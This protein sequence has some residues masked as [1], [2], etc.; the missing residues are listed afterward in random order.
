MWQPSYCTEQASSNVPSGYDE[1]WLFQPFTMFD[2]PTS[3]NEP[4]DTLSFPMA[5]SV[6]HFM[7]ADGLDTR[8][9]A[10]FPRVTEP[11][12]IP[13]T[14]S[15]INHVTASSSGTGAEDFTMQ[16]KSVPHHVIDPA[17]VFT[18][19]DEQPKTTVIGD[20]ANPHLVP[21][22]GE[23][24]RACKT[25]DRMER[26]SSPLHKRDL[27]DFILSLHKTDLYSHC[28]PQ[29]SC[30]HNGRSSSPR[31]H[32]PLYDDHDRLGARPYQRHPQRRKSDASPAILNSRDG[33]Q[34]S[35]PTLNSLDNHR[36]DIHGEARSSRHHDQPRRP[37]R[38]DDEKG[39]SLATSP[40]PRKRRRTLSPN[41]V[42]NNKDNGCQ[43]VR[44][45]V[46]DYGGE[47]QGR[48]QDT[49][50]QNAVNHPGSPLAERLHVNAPIEE[51]P[52]SSPTQVPL[53]ARTVRISDSD[54]RPTATNP[55]SES[56]ADDVDGC[57]ILGPNTLSP[58]E[59][60]HNPE[61][62]HE[63]DASDDEYDSGQLAR[64]GWLVDPW[65]NEKVKLHFS[66]EEVTAAL[67]NLEDKS[68]PF[69]IFATHWST[70]NQ[71]AMRNNGTFD[72]ECEKEGRRTTRWCRGV[73]V[74]QNRDREPNPCRFIMRPVTKNKK[75]DDQ[76]TK[77]CTN[78][79]CK[80]E[81]PLFRY[82]TCK[83]AQKLRIW[84][85]GATF[86]STG[87]HNHPR[88]ARVLHL[89]P[90]EQQEASEVVK[91]NPTLGPSALRYGRPD[92]VGPTRS[93]R[94]ISPAFA[95]RGR[96][97]SFVQKMK[98]KMKK[99]IG[100][101]EQIKAALDQLKSQFPDV[102][103]VSS[104]NLD[105]IN[106]HIQTPF[107]AS[108]A[109]Q[110]E[111]DTARANNGLV[112]D[113]P[114][115][116]FK[117]NDFLV[118]ITSAFS[119]DLFRWVP[120]LITVTSGHSAEHYKAHFYCLFEGIVLRC[121]GYG[122]RFLLQMLAMVRMFTIDTDFGKLTSIPRWL[123]TVRRSDGDLSWLLLKS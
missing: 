20:E 5:A 100:L 59:H 93:L 63:T 54:K 101:F 32:Y 46:D 10:P 78:G 80:A 41:Q 14:M 96:I 118:I 44:E 49:V 30:Q 39:D 60:V 23:C 25:N 13:H 2:R 47:L 76:K 69:G 40:R 17:R 11:S 3:Y 70:Y 7:I 27:L 31:L 15:T 73:F 16:M 72:G 28:P 120:V 12:A 19:K 57:A 119:V 112:T 56:R 77:V 92:L 1:N 95:N 91:L 8:V 75:L 55:L 85:H 87:R 51:S 29:S 53:V 38:F 109:C 98:N 105:F 26:Q 117:T 61:I 34:R 104:L 9:A 71:G 66:E 110:P 82:I 6:D 107:M 102:T 62:G 111:I 81:T 121:R 24:G 43:P 89:S 116:F 79:V 108:L 68:N 64:S 113:A 84:A 42:R 88:P 74:C 33:S 50:D 106:I 4:R 18:S 94:D 122:I 115:S 48:K 21:D 36:S 52:M 97:A 67:A 35:P 90:K 58:N 99:G 37:N 83:V 103:R 86:E 114:M 45:R 22:G 65:I 123:I